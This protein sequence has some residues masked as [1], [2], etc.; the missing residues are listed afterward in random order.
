MVFSDI[1]DQTITTNFGWYDRHIKADSRITLV[2][3]I[4]RQPSGSLR[5][6]VR[7]GDDPINSTG[8][9]SELLGMFS[10]NGDDE[11][12]NSGTKYYAFSMYIPTGFVLPCRWGIVLQ[13]HGPNSNRGAS[14]SPAFAVDVSHAEGRMTLNQRAGDI[15][16]P[17]ETYTDLG[18]MLYDTWIDLAFKVKWSAESDGTTA[19]WTRAGGKGVLQQKKISA[20]NTGAALPEL[21]G[22]TLYKSGGVAQSHYWKRGLYRNVEQLTSILY[23]GPFARAD[24]LQE[25][26]TEAFGQWP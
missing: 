10:R 9:R 19:I 13:L 5:V 1:K 8:E 16:T 24:T 21:S 11:N 22:A 14:A 4:R 3:E 2:Q 23:L 7:E 18:P 20:D 25:A 26:A 6:E 12:A 17:V 15:V